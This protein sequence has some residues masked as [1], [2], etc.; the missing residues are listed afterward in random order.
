MDET[1]TMP[2]RLPIPE[3]EPA[4]S[5][6]LG[7]GDAGKPRGRSR[8]LVRITRRSVRLLDREHLWGSIT[9]EL[10]SLRY[11]KLIADDDEA[12]IR[13]EVTQEK[14]AHIKDQ[15]TIVELTL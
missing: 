13:L 12:S 15:E 6:P 2:E 10:N 11:S 14:V 7:S 1:S 4:L 8:P 3:P 9:P 5:T